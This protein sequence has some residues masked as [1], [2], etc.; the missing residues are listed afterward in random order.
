MLDDVIEARTIEVAA[1]THPLCRD[2]IHSAVR[3]GTTVSEIVRLMDIDT[4]RYGLPYIVLIRGA[5]VWPVPITLWRNI[6]PKEGTRVEIAFPA[7]E[8]GAIVAAA[9]SAFLPTAAAAGAGALFGAATVGY[10]LTYAAI[11]VV[12]ALAINALI[13]PAQQGGGGTGPQN[14]AITGVANAANRY[15]VFPYV[16]GRHRIFPAMT[17]TGFSETVGRDI[18]YRGRMAISW[19]LVALEDLRIGNTPIWEYDGVE[20]EFLNVDQ[21]RTLP[22]MP[23]LADL[24]KP[25]TEE[26]R[27]V[28]R[29]LASEGEEF[30]FQPAEAARTAA[31]TIEPTA[32]LAGTTFDA[33]VEVAEVGSESWVEVETYTEIS[34]EQVFEAG[35]FSDG[36]AR[37]WRV[38]ITG[39]TISDEPDLSFGFTTLFE[40]REGL[41]VTTASASYQVPTAGWRYG[42][43]KMRLY[44]DDVTEDAYNDV[45]QESEPVIKYTR[46]DTVSAAVDLTFPQGLYNSTFDGDRSSHRARF[47]FEYQSTQGGINE[48]DWVSLGETEWSGKFYSLYRVTKEIA[49]PAPDEYAIRITRTNGIDDAPGD[50]NSAT[51][52]AIRSFSDRDL[53]S[54]EGI[55]EVAFR[56]KASD[57]LNGQID[58]LNAIVQQLAPVWDGTAWSDPQPVRHPAWAFLQAIR[59]KHLRR[60]VRD[61]RIDLEAFRAWAVEE[62]HWTCDYVVD[63]ATQLGEVLDIIAASGRAKRTLTDLKW[64]IIGDNAAGPVRQVF[65][66]RNSWGFRAEHR[67]PR[68][69]HGFRVKARSERLEWQEDEIF[70]LADG[71][72]R[73]TATELETLDL[74]GVVVTADDEDEGNVYRLGRYHLAAALNRHATYTLQVGWEHLRVTRGDKVRFV[75]DVPKVGVGQARIKAITEDGSGYVASIM[76]DDVLDFDQDTFRMLVRNVDGNQ[77]FTALSPVD[78]NARAWTPA[79]NVAASDIA[80][81][82]LVIVE[83]LTQE[84]VDLIVTSVRPK[85]DESAELQLVD[86]VPGIL[87]ADSGEIPTYS[88]VITEPRDPATAGM[89]PLP[90]IISAYSNSL[91]QIIAPDLSARPRIAVQLAPFASATD[92]EGVTL[93]LRWRDAEDLSAWSYGETVSAGEYNLTTRALD[94]GEAYLVEVRSVGPEGKTRGWVAVPNPVMASTA[95]PAPPVIS[96]TATAA[97]VPDADGNGRRPAISLSW[98]VPVNRTL[99]VTWQLRIA[100][101]GVVAQRG[102][103]AAA[104][105]GQVLISDGILP[106]TAYQIRA[107]FVSGAADLRT[108]GDWIDVTTDDLRFVEADLADGAV[109]YDKVAQDVKEAISAASQSAASDKAAAEAAALAAQAAETG[110]ETA[111]G[112]AQ[113]AQALAEDAHT[114]AAAARDAAQEAEANAEAA[115]ANAETAATNAGSAVTAAE[116]AR[117]AAVGAAGAA[118]GSATAA[119][120]FATT[121]S[122]HADDAAGSASAAS[123]SATTAQTA[124][125]NASTSAG[126]AATSETSAAGSASAAASSAVVAAEAGE[127]SLLRAGGNMFSNPNADDQSHFGASVGASLDVVTHGQPGTSSATALEVTQDT[128]GGSGFY[129]KWM[130]GLGP[131]AGRTIRFTVKARK[132]G[133]SGTVI[134][135]RAHLRHAKDPTSVHDFTQ[136]GA[137]A[138]YDLTETF[139]EYEFESAINETSVSNAIAW[140]PMIDG[141]TGGELIELTDFVVRDVTAEAQAQGHASAAATSASNAAA[142][143]TEAG[144][145]ASA[146][147]TARTGAETARG[148][149]ETAE[150]NAAQSETNAAG[151]ASSAATSATNAANSANDA[152]DSATAASNSASAASTSATNAGQSAS[153]ANTSANNA[154]TSAG[155]AS[156]SAGEASTSAGAAAASASDAAGSASSAATSEGLAAAA[157]FNAG[158][159]AQGNLTDDPAAADASLWGSS[160]GGQTTVETHGQSLPS[161]DTAI[162][163]TLTQ[164][165]GGCYALRYEGATPL[166]GRRLRIT[167]KVRGSANGNSISWTCQTGE[168]DGSYTPGPEYFTP[169]STAFQ[170]IS[171]D[172]DL[173]GIDSTHTALRFRIMQYGESS[174]Y[175]FEITDVVLEDVTESHAAYLSA[176]A[177]AGSA[178]SASSSADAAGESASAANTSETNAATSAGTASTKAGEASASASSA[179]GYSNQ[180]A[181]YSTVAATLSSGNM[182]RDANLDAGISEFW[183]GSSSSTPVYVTHGQPGT[184]NPRALRSQDASDGSGGFYSQPY[185]PG[186]WNDRVLRFRF[187]ARGSEAM[188]IACGIGYRMNNDTAWNGSDYDVVGTLPGD[189]SFAEYEHEVR[190][191]TDAATDHLALRWYHNGGAAGAWSE[192]TD[193]EVFD[194]TAEV[195]A[196][197]SANAAASSASTADSY[198]DDAEAFASAANTSATNAAT[199]ES[200]ANTFANQAS[201]AKQ[202][203]E[204]A[205]SSAIDASGVAVAAQN[206]ASSSASAASNS[207]DAAFGYA[208][209]AEAYAGAASQDAQDAAADAADALAY[210]NTAVGARDDAETAAASA[211]SWA[212]VAATVSKEG[213]NL[214]PIFNDGLFEYFS[215]D[216][217]GSITIS[218]ADPKYSQ[219]VVMESA[220]TPTNDRPLLQY[221]NYYSNYRL[222]GAHMHEWVK[223]VVEIEKTAGDIQCG[224]QITGQ[225]SG[226][227]T[228]FSSVCIE[229]QLIQRVNAIQR[230]EVILQR[231]AGYTKNTND[232]NLYVGLYA[233]TDHPDGSGRKYV[234]FRV[235]SFTVTSLN[236]QAT[237]TLTQRAVAKQDGWASSLTALRSRAGSAGAELELVALSDEGGSASSARLAA[238]NI[239]LEGSVYAKH[240]TVGDTSNMIPDAGML[241]GSQWTLS[242]FSIGNASDN[243][244]A[245][246]GKRLHL[247]EEDLTG[248]SDAHYKS[249]YTPYSPIEPGRSYRFSCDFR[250]GWFS[251]S[252]R[253][254]AVAHFYDAAGN[255]L[256]GGGW[257]GEFSVGVHTDEQRVSGIFQAP[258]NA[259]MARIQ[260][261]TAYDGSGEIR[262]PKNFYNFSVRPAVDPSLVVDGLIKANSALIEDAAIGTLKIAGNAVVMPVHAQ[263]GSVTQLPSYSSWVSGIAYVNIERAAGLPTQIMFGGQLAG[264]PPFVRF[265]DGAVAGFRV[266]RNGVV[267]AQ[268]LAHCSGFKGSRSTFSFTVQDNDRSGGVVRYAIQAIRISSNRNDKTP[269]II[270]PWMRATQ[271]K[272]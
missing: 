219:Y 255:T 205:E 243:D 209:D 81:G 38:R 11:T 43:E 170:E 86:A 5:E 63:T 250:A 239:L 217:E 107:S 65:T 1:E 131:V 105:E 15:G 200:N 198:R 248:S 12:G 236:A 159:R 143:E 211:Q 212:G 62:P 133:S 146:A 69:I 183:G 116:M 97:S 85:A 77:A 265:G 71:F 151:S 166:Q 31:I 56:I 158:T 35:P 46:L 222:G 223:V 247:N 216:D 91:T 263:F 147:Q 252:G 196:G 251:S 144:Q 22:N 233:T 122:S 29:L 75:H 2:V 50:Y 127:L 164:E 155:N 226:V 121:A 137:P 257:L 59:G 19:D 58:S 44:A 177:A 156:T 262:G 120:G 229:D 21:A 100:A 8:G 195:D 163:V 130:E 139:E 245:Q 240:L 173:T 215:Y 150:C 174:G 258:A 267:I 104:S 18:Y 213:G 48:A 188:Q 246:S 41:T 117:D 182:V 39:K 192:I 90:V 128:D 234:Q 4:A 9:A 167:A 237:A 36:V 88:P 225:W 87:G 132:V 98:I 206:S 254:M 53:P 57:Q 26:S 30:V 161:S 6:R 82:D 3:A 169:Y 89:P 261:R 74:P 241:D 185:H 99:R 34:T 72:T 228:V 16:I 23:Q 106:A 64:S 218:D 33:V 113:A 96:A 124:A 194:V 55:A 118:D 154:S 79:V 214:N 123:G 171:F 232:D 60:P 119:S 178:S 208:D 95:A 181:T 230:V 102:L 101:T 111:Q 94:E 269:Q 136:I 210:R 264:V 193:L 47:V 184:R 66:P 140:R 149:A 142:S 266:I 112:L 256:S 268:N 186:N 272:R 242:D 231:P 207:A 51:L 70:V 78:P 189:Q 165:F 249:A 49:F 157:E 109:T 108:W 197:L 80:V 37:R 125:G 176:N 67:F 76:L 180:A 153:A 110:A 32:L 103:F 14:Y 202:D 168:G 270:M 221:R 259:V 162:R 126:N 73:Q 203:A 52:T 145:S 7:Q 28:K 253:A 138:S 135:L 25:R 172:V 27:T 17:A 201:Q 20:L 271:Y 129:L 54:H 42:A 260:A 199:A 83:E 45:P 134:N 220:A 61:E 160:S 148:G 93:Q 114:D 224:T 40:G 13:P 204:S 24:V 175:W 68:E 92:L 152:G 190:A 238:D 141:G 187:K 244:S 191:N 235:H 10:A 179:E 84:S 115:R 227:T